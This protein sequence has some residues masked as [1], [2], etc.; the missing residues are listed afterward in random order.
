MTDVYTGTLSKWDARKGFGFV[1]QEGGKVGS[2]T[3]KNW[4]CH[5]KKF[6][7]DLTP[8]D[9]KDGMT[10]SYKIREQLIGQHQPTLT[11]P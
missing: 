7:P 5:K 2:A 10:L 11:Q 9:V 4:F 6:G 8:D 1:S 3:K